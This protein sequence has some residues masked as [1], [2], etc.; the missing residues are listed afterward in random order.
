MKYTGVRIYIF[1]SDLT[2]LMEKY[3]ELSGGIIHSVCICQLKFLSVCSP[4]D[5]ITFK[6]LILLS[7]FLQLD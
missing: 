5:L 4:S 1:V 7:Q 6:F 2:V 3:A